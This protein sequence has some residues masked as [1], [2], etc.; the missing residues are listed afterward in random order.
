[1]P[2]SLGLELKGG[3]GD[4]GYFRIIDHFGRSKKINI[5]FLTGMEGTR[6]SANASKF[7]LILRTSQDLLQSLQ[8]R[9]TY[10]LY[11]QQS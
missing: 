3:T 11:D 7:L 9:G 1:M 8:V 4:G 2:S 10:E 6:F 5:V